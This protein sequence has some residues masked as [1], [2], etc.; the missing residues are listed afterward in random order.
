MPGASGARPTRTAPPAPRRQAVLAA[1]ALAACLFPAPA[2]SASPPFRLPQPVVRKLANGVTVAVFRDTRLPLAQV[3]ITVPAGSAAEDSLPEGA[4]Y[5]TSQLVGQAT[6]TRDPK[7]MQEDLDRLG[8]RLSTRIGRDVAVVT[9]TFLSSQLSSG[10]ELLGDAV[11]NALLTDAEFERVR[12]VTRAR[13]LSPAAADRQAE[14][15]LWHAAFGKGSYGRA[16]GG[17]GESLQRLTLADVRAFYR[18]HWGPSGTVLAIAGDIEPDSAFAWV[19][20]AFGAW[21]E[22]GASPAAAAASAGSGARS[23]Q[24]IPRAGAPKCQVWVGV[25]GPSAGDA[26]EVSISFAHQLATRAGGG[27]RAGQSALR[28]GGFLWLSADATPDSAA[29]VA[30]RLESALTSLRATPPRAADVEALRQAIQS[31]FPMR[32]ESLEGLADQWCAEAALGHDFDD[33]VAFP[34]RVRAVTPASITAAARK[35]FDPARIVFVVTGPTDRARASLV[36]VAPIAAAAAPAPV[37]KASA[38]TAAQQ[39]RGR[40]LVTQA[41]TA[42]G[43]LAALKRVQDSVLEADATVKLGSGEA[44]AKIVLTRKEPD[45]MVYDLRFESSGTREVLSGRSA[46]SAPLDSLQL[47]QESDTIGVARLRRGFR[48]DVLHLLLDAALPATRLAARGTTQAN[49]KTFES[50]EVATPDGLRRTLFFEPGTH[51][52][53]GVELQEAGDREGGAQARRWYSDYRA[54]DGIQL[55]FEEDRRLGEQRVMELKI[56]RYALNSGV[57]DAVF[58]RPDSPLPPPSR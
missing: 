24:L 50:V 34:D 25:P 38:P 9:A 18:T 29:R 8:G 56:T 42:H 22:R 37:A 31:T 10:L 4:A 12:R 15:R 44:N 35:W 14:D 55:P 58:E 23:L 45:R 2:Q 16:P 47:V 21:S 11:L 39:R 20:D 41:V 36:R 3:Q 43:G 17:T 27:T 30:K 32:F 49:G 40:E 57:P 7:A 52:L 54:V 5:V 46:W 13:A 6:A 48:T 33:L 53:A 51:L 26:D 19:T 1:V 28:T